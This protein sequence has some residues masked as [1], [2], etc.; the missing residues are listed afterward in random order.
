MQDS[1]KMN[2]CPIC[3]RKTFLMSCCGKLIIKKNDKDKRDTT[4]SE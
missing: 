2:T 1:K 3:K 4:V